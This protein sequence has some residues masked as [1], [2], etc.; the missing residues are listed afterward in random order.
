MYSSFRNKGDQIMFILEAIPM[1][2]IYMLFAYI[3]L[4][5][6]NES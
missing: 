3:I 6:E 2:L 1:I 4:G 5:G